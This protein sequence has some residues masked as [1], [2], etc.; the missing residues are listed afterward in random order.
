M[1]RRGLV[2]LT[3]ALGLAALAGPVAIAL[4]AQRGEAAFGD[5]ESFGL[6]RVT[7]ASVSIAVGSNTVPIETA[8]LAPGDRLLGQI[9]FENQGS[10]PLRYA[11]TADTSTVGVVPLLDVLRWKIWPGSAGGVCSPASAAGQLLFDG[12]MDQSIVLGDPAIGQDPGDRLVDVLTTDLLCMEV[13]LPIGV[14]DEYQ[15]VGATVELFAIAE[16]ATEALD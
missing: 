11:L 9:V 5:S 8:M 12:V 4:G 16:Q 7:S 15:A 2:I 14:S 3:I 1:R 10:L 6:N 13:E